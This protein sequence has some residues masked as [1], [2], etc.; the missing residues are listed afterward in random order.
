[1]KPINCLLALLFAFNLSYAQ[2]NG[3]FNVLKIPPLE[4]SPAY[5]YMDTNIPAN[6]IAAP[7]IHINGYTYGAVNKAL[8]VTLGWYYYAG[9]FFWT[10]YQSDLG[11][12][13]PSR[14]RIGKYT[15][16]GSDY[17]RIEISNN[18]TYWSNYN[19]TATDKSDD[20]SASYTGWTYTEGEMPTATTSQITVVN[21]PTNV[22]IDGNVGIGT[23]SPDEKLTVNGTIHASEVKVNTNIPVPDY[24]FEKDYKLKSLKEVQDYITLNKHL[25]EIPSAKEMDKSGINIS[26]LNMKLLQK[27]EEL[28]LYLIEQNKMLSEQN[29]KLTDQQK[30]I[31]K[32]NRK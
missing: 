4:S 2:T 20:L 13:K 21:R 27:V 23:A 28:T 3:F 26:E 17:I 5:F 29:Q 18:S 9:N 24:V 7:Q 14:I 11:Y 16:G 30:Q 19:I 6:D 1:M 25:P 32:L 15:K 10:Q 12:E 22:I 8:K 31:E